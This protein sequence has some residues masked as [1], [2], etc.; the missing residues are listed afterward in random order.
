MAKTAAPKKQFNPMQIF[1][2]VSVVTSFAAQV[3]IAVQGKAGAALRNA[4]IKC[5]E[6]ALPVVEQVTGK[7]LLNDDKF[8]EA[9]RSLV[10]AFIEAPAK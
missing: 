8:S 5:V 4:I 10:D 3:Y 7:D 6:N 2:I 9:M 1:A